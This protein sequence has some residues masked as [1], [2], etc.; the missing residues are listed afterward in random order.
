M[1]SCALNNHLIAPQRVSDLI[2]VHKAGLQRASQSIR[3]Y[4]EAHPNLK[5]AAEQAPLDDIF[6]LRFILSAKG[7]NV[8]S[9]INN[10]KQTLEWRSKRLPELEAARQGKVKYEDVTKRYRSYNIIGFLNESHPTAVLRVCSAAPSGLFN[11]LSSEKVT[12]NI[13]LNEERHFHLCDTKTRETGFLCKQVVIV[14]LRGFS[15]SMYDRRFGKAAVKAS[16]ESA[17]YY[18]QLLG[19]RVIINMPFGLRVV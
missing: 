5:A 18:P 4:L 7:N 1:S 10:I 14:D 12:E 11:Q 17:I 13:L 16:R 6:I 2:N 19:K 9:A 3:E 8:E 15:L